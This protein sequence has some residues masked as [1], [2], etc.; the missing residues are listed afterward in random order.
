MLESVDE[1]INLLITTLE[2]T[3]NGLTLVDGS[4]NTATGTISA[5]TQTTETMAYSLAEINSLANSI[6]GIINMI[7]GGIDFSDTQNMDLAN[8]VQTMTT[9]LNQI[10]SSL[11]E[12]Q[13]VVDNFQLTV[14]N[15]ITQLET[16]QQNTLTWI[17][18]I[19]TILTTI[20]VWL[21]IAQV[22]LLLQ[23]VETIR[24]K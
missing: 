11:A 12:V 13:E 5:T 4:L 14:D 15:T 21:G 8:D 10:N 24:K 2:T 9:N 3:S 22:G 17:T 19:A 1:T 18:V 23:G 6:V 20:L 16:I 7:G